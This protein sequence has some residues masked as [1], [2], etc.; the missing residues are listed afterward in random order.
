MTEAR[1]DLVSFDLHGDLVS[2]SEAATLAG[3]DAATV[4]QRPA[5]RTPATR[6]QR[7]AGVHGSAGLRWK[8]RRR[9]TCGPLHKNR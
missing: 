6:A 7:A 2:V 3:V 5:P 1:H 9:P 4:R 8:R